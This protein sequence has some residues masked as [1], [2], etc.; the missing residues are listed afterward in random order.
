MKLFKFDIDIYEWTIQLVKLETGDE[1]EIIPEDIMENLMTETQEGID[2]WFVNEV[3]NAGYTDANIKNKTIYVIFSPQTSLKKAANTYFHEA[4]HIVDN[5][6][7]Y[8]NILDEEA[9]AYLQGYIGEYLYD[10][11]LK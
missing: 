8:C 7:Q 11:M 4:R 10:F 9:S 1:P 6:V 5:I 3:M 2:E